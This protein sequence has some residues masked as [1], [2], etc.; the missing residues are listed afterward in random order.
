[1]SLARDVASV[2]TA[3]LASR[4]L[5]FLRDMWIASL[6]GTGIAADAFFAILQLVNVLRHT[7]AE[8][9]LNT[10]FIP[11]WLRVRDQNGEP[12]AVRFVQ[13]VLI[14]TILVAG[15]VAFIGYFFAPPVVSI[16]MP[17]FD[18]ER[19]DAAAIYLRGASPY[20]LLAA[21]G[22][23]FVA[24][25]CAKGRVGAAS[26]GIVA[27]NTVLLGALALARASGIETPAAIGTLLAHA[28]ALGGL[29]Q[30]VVTGFALWRLKAWTIFKRRQRLSFFQE[31]F[32]ICARTKSALAKS[33]CTK[34]TW[35]FFALAAPGLLAA[36]MPQIKLMAGAMVASSSAASVSWLYY[37]NRL[38]EL[39][40]A[41]ASVIIATVLAP[42][43]AAGTGAADDTTIAGLQTHALEIALGIAMPAA[44]ALALL[45][46]D[47]V[48]GLFE[49]GAFGAS[50]TAAVAAALVVICIGLPGHA[51]EKVF[52][53]VSLA[54]EDARTPMLAALTGFA[55]AVAGA[56][57]LFPA[58]G[59]VGIAAAIGLSGWVAAMSAGTM[60]MRRGWLRIDRTVGGRLLRLVAASGVMGVAL[61]LLQAVVTAQIDRASSSAMRFVV[62]VVLTATGLAAYVAALQLFGVVRFRNL[63]AELRGRI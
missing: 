55:T 39:P 26:I 52:S 56:F 38:Y 4:I 16:L 51:L 6:L 44:L 5:A 63:A 46:H 19:H 34:S 18:A 30:V 28:I 58:H 41:V 21:V 1:M 12:G 2:G 42:R 36:G 3:T 48:G 53:A 62:L 59:H 9:A 11:I 49:R 7:L 43:I 47:I 10:A 27:F 33:T 20:V 54:H 31:A 32:S 61:V 24:W 13:D 45:A 29:A 40:L 22:A 57:A 17:G 60:L 50:D 8:G 14:A 37:T 15:I 23:V 25:L 35:R